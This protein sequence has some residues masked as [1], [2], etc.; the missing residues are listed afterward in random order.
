MCKVKICFLPLVRRK[1]STQCLVLCITI[2]IINYILLYYIESSSHTILFHIIEKLEH[3]IKRSYIHNLQQEL[4]SEWIYLP[5][6]NQQNKKIFWIHIPRTSGNSI[7]TDLIGKNAHW[8]IDYAWWEKENVPFNINNPKH[9]SAH[10]VYKLWSNQSIQVIKGWFSWRNV[11]QYNGLGSKN[12]KVFTILRYPTERIYSLYKRLTTYNN[13]NKIKCPLLHSLFD[14]IQI[15]NTLIPNGQCLTLNEFL[16]IN[17]CRF[18]SLINNYMTWQLSD[19][20]Q[21]RRCDDINDTLH[22]IQYEIAKK[23]LLQLDFIGFYEDMY[24][25]F[26]LLHQ[27]IFP[28]VQGSWLLRQVFNMG[29]FIAQPRMK[30]LKYSSMMNGMDLELIKEKNKYDIMLYEYAKMLMNKTFKLYESYGEYVLDW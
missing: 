28:D 30:V 22:R 21:A 24:N 26:E 14:T 5:N 15:N 4:S 10:K 13:E 29:T 18:Q 17:N 8:L 27:R 11:H 1:R 7:R 16:H 6:N 2:C 12:K 25:D 20:I 23:H 3:F 19:Q 9:G